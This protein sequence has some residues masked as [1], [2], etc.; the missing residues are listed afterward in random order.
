MERPRGAAW[1]SAHGK[2]QVHR[3]DS[4]LQSAKKVFSEKGYQRIG[5]VL[6]GRPYHND[7]GVC[8]EILAEFRLW[9]IPSSLRTA[10]HRRGYPRAALRRRRAAGS[11]QPSDWRLGAV[12]IRAPIHG[13]VDRIAGRVGRIERLSGHGP[14]PSNIP[15]RSRACEPGASTPELGKLSLQDTRGR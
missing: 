9:D 14:V 13:M 2:S 15:H 6:L 3:R 4:V 12:T 5:V 10:A 7:P 8:H 1:R 11:D